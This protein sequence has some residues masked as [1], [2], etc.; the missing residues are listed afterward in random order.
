MKDTQSVISGSFIIQ[1]LLDEYWDYSDIDIYVSTH[2]NN[3]HSPKKPEERADY[4]KSDV[5]DFMYYNMK[6]EGSHNNYEID[7]CIKWV[8]DYLPDTTYSDGD[9]G[10]YELIRKNN[11]Q[12]HYNVQII[13][14]DVDKT[15][16]SLKTFIDT[17]FDFTICKNMYFYDGKDNIILSN[18]NEIFTRETN[19]VSTRNLSSTIERYH[20]YTEKGKFIFRN[21]NT[22]TY[23]EIKDS[24]KELTIYAN[25]NYSNKIITNF[26][27]CININYCNIAL[28]GLLVCNINSCIINFLD[29]NIKHDHIYFNEYTENNILIH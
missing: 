23:D 21:K 3:V 24:D 6:F 28:R 9:Y 22:I 15:Y 13:G 10:K 26:F 29:K 17:T 18:L 19:F 20:K 12:S 11:P 2:D 5:D 8:R 4:I 7:N 1:C 14:I 16:D 25:K 27:K